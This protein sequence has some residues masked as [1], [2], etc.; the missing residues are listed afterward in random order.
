MTKDTLAQGQG[1]TTSSP[2]S[3]SKKRVRMDI[4]DASGSFDRPPPRS[5]QQK[6]MPAAAA[7]S[8]TATLPSTG[9]DVLLIGRSDLCRPLAESMLSVTF[10][11]ASLSSGG[12]TRKG[13]SEK[14][15]KR[16]RR[17][18]DAGMETS[19]SAGTG[20]GSSSLRSDAAV[21]AL[22]R[23]LSRTSSGD[24][25]ASINGGVGSFGL[26]DAVKARHVRLVDSLS[27][28]P[29]PST[30]STDGG[31]SGVS[32]CNQNNSGERAGSSS[33]GSADP[34]VDHVA[35]VVTASDPLSSTRLRQTA[36]SLHPDYAIG[37]RVTI[38]NVF[39]E[40]ADE[41]GPA[42]VVCRDLEGLLEQVENGDNGSSS[43]SARS[44][45]RRKSAGVLKTV[46]SSSSVLFPAP[47]PVLRCDLG[48][49]QSRLAVARMILQRVKMGSRGCMGADDGM[50]AA[51]AG[52]YGAGRG[53]YGSTGDGIPPSS[54]VH[55]VHSHVV[56]N[57]GREE[58]DVLL[59]GARGGVSPLFFS[60][61]L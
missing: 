12:N 46:M 28:L 57:S 47:V 4:G 16:L 2:A 42:K 49:G 54:E 60:S 36:L 43:I 10:D 35:I 40:S 59:D 27:D 18:S 48:D 24:G 45:K 7:E 25:N 17:G 50:A 14:R 52:N 23:H 44:G 58:L 22:R 20:S 38:V 34:R 55:N 15:R 6:V 30:L 5:D 61:I 29:A 26:A 51:F 56:E 37:G 39:D 32:L 1:S 19:S 31:P 11:R 9:L 8:Y 41:Y 53:D 3:K 21:E 33:D 13:G